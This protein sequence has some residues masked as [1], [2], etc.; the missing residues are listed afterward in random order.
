MQVRLKAAL[1]HFLISFVIICVCFFW[2]LTQWFP[3]PHFWI[4]GGIQ[5][6]SIV[7]PVDFVMGPILM[8]IIYNIKKPKSEL[9]RDIAIIA[10]LQLCVLAYGLSKVYS[11]RVSTE[12]LIFNGIIGVPSLGELEERN[13]DF[14]LGNLHERFYYGYQPILTYV[15]RPSLSP[16]VSSLKSL[17][18]ASKLLSIEKKPRKSFVLMDTKVNK[19]DA[20]ATIGAEFRYPLYRS[21]KERH[22]LKKVVYLSKNSLQSLQKKEGNRKAIEEF[23]SKKSADISSF[24]FFEV[25]AKYGSAIKVLDKDAKPITYLNVKR[26]DE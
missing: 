6:L 1:F 17:F 3:Y 18:S 24:M 20:F 14:K 10:T 15:E 16:K 8:I 21:L 2:I 22:I 9:I 19:D 12:A 11:Q 4:S 23:S 26:Y 5:G 7:I 25:R 13:P